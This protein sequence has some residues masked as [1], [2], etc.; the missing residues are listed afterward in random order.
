MYHVDTETGLLTEASKNT[1]T[2]PDDGP[3]HVWPHPN[4]RLV[5]SLQEHTSMVD[6]FRL[7]D[8]DQKLEFVEGASIIPPGESAK[9]YW[10]DEVRLSPDA[11]VLFGSTRGL[12]PKTKGWVTAWRLS[13]D[14]R[15]LNADAAAKG[16]ATHRFE[17][18]T[19]GGW[20]NAIAVCSNFGPNGETFL[21]LTDSEEGFVQVLSY[22]PESGFK[23]VDEVKVG[24]KDKPVGASVTV[25]L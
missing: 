24:N 21:T 2:R 1:A 12:E 23:V 13:P 19:S 20:A 8:D 22:L 25:W 6:V 11:S 4:G 9:R 7:S 3:R 5:Y 18:R 15:I 16:E 17:T 10:A 14:G